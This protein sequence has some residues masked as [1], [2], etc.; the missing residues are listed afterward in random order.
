MCNTSGFVFLFWPH[1]TNG[2][3]ALSMLFVCFCT[4]KKYCTH[5]RTTFS[6]WVKYKTSPTSHFWEDSHKL[7]TQNWGEVTRENS[8]V[9]FSVKRLHRY[10]MAGVGVL[11]FGQKAD[12]FWRIRPFFWTYPSGG[13]REFEGFCVYTSSNMNGFLGHTKIQWTNHWTI[14]FIMT[15]IFRLEGPQHNH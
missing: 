2:I 4:P 1:T 3:S 8:S 15:A 12:R 13:S 14:R 5:R 10:E 7:C 9:D 11:F 6:I